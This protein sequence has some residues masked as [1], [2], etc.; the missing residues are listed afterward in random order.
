MLTKHPATGCAGGT[1]Y[2]S[3]TAAVQ[4]MSEFP[5][6]TV[7]AVF[8]DG[9]CKGGW[10]MGH[11]LNAVKASGTIRYFDFQTM[12]KGAW[13]GNRNPASCNIPFCGV[14]TQALSMSKRDDRLMHLGGDKQPGAYNTAKLGMV[15]LAFPPQTP[16]PHPEGTGGAGGF[17]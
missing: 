4:F 17:A 12:H 10:P 9:I 3:Y 13:G 15:V 14:K 6:K 5:D 8:C 1:S 11:W 2:L 16:R 7:F